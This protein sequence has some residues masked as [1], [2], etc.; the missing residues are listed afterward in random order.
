MRHFALLLAAAFLA[1]QA[2][3][4]AQETFVISAPA[5]AN[6]KPIPPRFSQ[7]GGNVSP[8]LRI[9]GVPA[10]TVSLVLIVD[11]RDA[12]SG[13]WTHWML[14]DLLPSTKVIPEGKVPTGAV[15]GKNSFG[16]SRYDGP[17]PPSG[18]HRYEFHLYAL[19]HKT[20]LSPGYD[21]AALDDRIGSHYISTFEMYGTFSANP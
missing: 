4:L 15:Q 21:R 19:S 6:G 3:C 18:T 7:K 10:G 13:L 9:S 20:G 11:D 14:A 12:P 1:G 2:C 8:E 16:N 17:N 5:F